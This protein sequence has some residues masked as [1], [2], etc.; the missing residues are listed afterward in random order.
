LGSAHQSSGDLAARCL[1]VPRSNNREML[2]IRTRPDFDSL[3]GKPAE[4]AAP[5]P[6]NI[7]AYRYFQDAGTS[8]P[9]DI[10]DTPPAT[11]PANAPRETYAHHTR[12]V[13]E[14]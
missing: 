6:Y 7:V 14:L 3:D 2:F 13:W 4:D 10:Y 9:S 12:L 8:Y 5:R 1:L 11:N